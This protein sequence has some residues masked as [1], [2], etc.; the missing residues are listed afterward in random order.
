M[1]AHV[2]CM[3][4][5]WHGCY[6]CTFSIAPTGVSGSFLKQGEAH[7]VFA[8]SSIQLFHAQSAIYGEFQG[9][10]V[11]S[12]PGQFQT[13]LDMGMGNYRRVLGNDV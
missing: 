6:P 7:L 11:H 4:Y 2:L 8:N 3:T 10:L 9:C 5:V 13:V 12:Y 1:V